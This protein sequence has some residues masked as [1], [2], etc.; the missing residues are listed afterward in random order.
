[1]FANA[2]ALYQTCS[3]RC[4]P[5]GLQ[6]CTIFH[7][8]GRVRSK[9]NERLIN[10]LTL[11]YR[12]NIQREDRMN[13]RTELVSLVTWH[14]LKNTTSC[15]MLSVSHTKERKGSNKHLIRIMFKII[16]I[17]NKTDQQMQFTLVYFLNTTQSITYDM[18]PVL[19]IIYNNYTCILEHQ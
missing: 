3:E 18:T 12:F 2:L 7:M 15:Q 6:N 17:S 1:M 10:S 16:W 13:Q 5:I 14:E 9:M 11:C 19:H 4:C 8:I